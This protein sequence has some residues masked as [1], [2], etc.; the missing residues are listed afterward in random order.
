MRRFELKEG[1]FQELGSSKIKYFWNCL[2]YF[3]T[4]GFFKA[5][6]FL[7]LR[8][9][10]TRAFIDVLAVNP[11]MKTTEIGVPDVEVFENYGEIA[12][13]IERLPALDE[14]EK[15]A[16]LLS[17]ASRKDFE[18]LEVVD[19]WREPGSTY[20]VFLFE[21]V[22]SD[23]KLELEKVVKKSSSFCLK[24][25]KG[26]DVDF[27]KSPGLGLFGR[28]GSGKTTTLLAFLFQ[29]LM[30]G[31]QVCL[32]DGKNELQILDNLVKRAYRLDTI[33]NLL[34]IA[35]SELERRE[36]LLSE[37][38]AQSGRLGLKAS[39][40][41]L[42]PFVV[43]VDELG[44]VVASADSK[45]KAKLV[46]LLTQIALKGRSCG[47]VLV[48]SSQFA[49]VETIPN[50]IRSQLSTKILLGSA[51]A[52]LVRMVFPQSAGGAKSARQ[53]EGFVFVEGQRGREPARFQVPALGYLQD[54]TKWVSFIES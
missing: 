35:V 36:A 28:S 26:L 29:F 22:A 19:F 25:Q 9:M 14:D 13:K 12:C 7:K 51:P 21:D 16:E 23:K 43:A 49:S 53:F 27:E 40:I 33:M 15:L 11:M 47:V 10:I 42:N 3:R 46:A 54:V 1:R 52:E 2:H 45:E 48:V 30:N 18:A 8:K 37:A 34:E 38:S 39:E 20:S 24:L 44:A 6:K 31:A 41:A 50:A 5:L 32:I 17:V 4:F